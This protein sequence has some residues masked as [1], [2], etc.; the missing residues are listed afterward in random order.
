MGV[1]LGPAFTLATMVFTL[2]VAEPKDLPPGTLQAEVDVALRAWQ[3]PA[4]SGFRATLTLRQPISAQSDGVNGVFW[5]E[6]EWPET[7]T[8]G[9]LA[10]TVVTRGPDGQI[11]D[12][13]IHLNGKSFRFAVDGTPGTAD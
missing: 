5:H 2:D 11:A 6:D 8:P 7:L 12:A 1:V 10:E 3:R 4:C 9:V 13:D